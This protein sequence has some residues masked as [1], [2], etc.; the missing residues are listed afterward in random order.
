MKKRC[1]R[2]KKS[3]NTSEFHKNRAKPD[4]LHHY[5][6]Q[7]RSEHT[8]AHRDVKAQYDRNWRRQ[9]PERSRGYSK[10][11]RDD[12]PE[13]CR[14]RRRRYKLSKRQSLGDVPTNIEVLLFT[15]QKG[16]CYYCGDKLVEFELEHMVPLSRGGAH[17]KSNLCLSCVGCNRSKFTKTADEFLEAMNS[18]PQN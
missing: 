1:A 17:D 14:E 13:K 5:C 2:C 8:K 11:W 16:R 12:N 10:R 9:N 15:S 4:G 3:K 6:K 7:C 18:G